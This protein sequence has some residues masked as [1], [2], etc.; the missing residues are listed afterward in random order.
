[1]RDE[2]S[3]YCDSEPTSGMMKDTVLPSPLIDA[4]TELLFKLMKMAGIP[5]GVHSPNYL[6]MILMALWQSSHTCKSWKM[7]SGVPEGVLIS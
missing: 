5:Y 2:P 3:P 1:M 6:G 7:Q 4:R